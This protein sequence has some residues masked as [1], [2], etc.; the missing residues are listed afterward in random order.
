MNH[1]A[2]S[3]L[4]RGDVFSFANQEHLVVHAYDVD[5]HDWRE[6]SLRVVVCSSG[7]VLRGDPWMP[8]DRQ[9]AVVASAL[10]AAAR[11]VLP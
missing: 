8:E 5:P 11:A 2:L 6:P 1:A 4:T 7:L 10:G 3:A 9:V